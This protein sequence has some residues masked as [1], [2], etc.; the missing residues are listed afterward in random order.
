MFKK[1]TVIPAIDLKGGEVVRLMRGDLAQATVYRRE[2]A[3]VAREF[4][5]EGAQ[6]IHVVDLDGA[7][8]GEPRNLG[9]IRAIR[10]AVS[11][12]IDVSGGLRTIDSVRAAFASGAN[13]ISIGSAAILRPELL[14]QAGREFPQRVIGSLDIRGGRPAI[15]GWVES[16]QLSAADTLARFKTAG[17]VAATVTDI[18]RDG[19]EQG[20]DA[21]AMVGL[22]RDSGVPIIASGGI[23][24][25]ADLAILASCFNQ[26][27]I[28]VVVGRALY[29]RRFSL[30]EAL[31]VSG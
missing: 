15:K 1:F 7:I 10:E 17:A 20:V 18:S 3:T 2:P 12:A 24:S 8:A 21:A 6:L 13:Y 28:G 27:I 9:A 4:E 26:G 30:V 29:E 31:S 14:T 22:A 23:A 25:L 11:C 5:A 16:S 19:T